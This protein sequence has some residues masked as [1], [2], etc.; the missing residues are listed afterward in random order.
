MSSSTL[1]LA[2]G[3]A[4]VREH[5]LDP[6]L[7]R[8]VASGRQR[9]QEAPPWRRVEVRWVDLKAGTHLQTVSYDAT[10][11]HTA[12]AAAG[13]PAAACVDALLATPYG[14]W[15]VTTARAVVQLRI[16]KKGQAF[17]HVGPAEGASAAP[18][19]RSHDRAK[20]RLLPEDDALFAALGLAGK[21]GRIRPSRQAK[22]RQIEEFVGLLDAAVSDA[23]GAGHLRTP[24][25]EDPLRIVDLGCGNGYLTFAAHRYL[26]DRRG[27]PV[28]MT[29]VDVKEQ[30]RAHNASVAADLG[31]DADFVVG[32]I[33]DA[34]LPQPP[35]VVLALHACDTAT[36]EA[37]ARAVEWQAPLVLAAPCCHHDI[38]AQLRRTP[39]P[40]PYAA[41]VRDGILRE[42]FADTLTDALRGLLLRGA[43]YRVEVV[44]FV[45]SKHTPRNTLLRA[46]RTGGAGPGASAARAEYDD[47]TATWGLHPRLGVLLA[48]SSSGPSDAPR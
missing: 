34:A 29:G 14:N 41:L 19:S 2:D 22:Y 40:E 10:Q 17:V 30:S 46:V 36:D 5:L 11:A 47:L 13:E 21:D 39:P 32:T 8:A 26:S 7:V 28:R 1:P 48:A 37:L 44:Q 12:N 16:T 24:T 38:A 18:A 31:I 4:V 15:H 25:P 27:L 3:L 6:D 9:G 33:A 45:E 42:R 35:D 43:G 23:I 20:Q